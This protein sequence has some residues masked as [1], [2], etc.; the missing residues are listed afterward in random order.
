MA[1]LVRKRTLQNVASVY[2]KLEGLTRLAG[3]LG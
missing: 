3:F 2:K 1:A